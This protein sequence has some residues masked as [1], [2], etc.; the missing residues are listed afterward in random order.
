[1]DGLLLVARRILPTL[2]ADSNAVRVRWDTRY[3][4]CGKQKLALMDLQN[5]C[6]SSTGSAV[7]VSAGF[8]PIGLGTETDGSIVQPAARAA[9][10]AIKP[11]PGTTE[12]DGIWMVSDVFDAVAG[13]AKSTRD[14]ALVTEIVLNDD[15]RSKLPKDGYLSNLKTNFSG[16]S[17]GFLDPGVWRWPPHVQKQEE[18]TLEQIVGRSR[19]ERTGIPPIYQHKP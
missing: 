7:G 6:G 1:M 5:P 10:Y 13:M 3:V 14:L 18:G 19:M 15:A 4:V 17:I 9:L 16:L 8:S 12:M 2:K 11:T